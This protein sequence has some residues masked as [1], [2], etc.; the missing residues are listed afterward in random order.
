MPHVLQR[1]RDALSAPRQARIG[2]SVT[3][4]ADDDAARTLAMAFAASIACH[5]LL[6]ADW[7]SNPLPDALQ[8]SLFYGM[9]SAGA[10]QDASLRVE[11][12]SARG[13]DVTAEA[14]PPAAAPG[15]ANDIA[16]APAPIAPVRK[17]PAVPP[18]PPPPVDS[19]QGLVNVVEFDDIGAVDSTLAEAIGAEF[20]GTVDTRPQL[21]Q[22]LA[23]AYPEDALRAHRRMVVGV[24]VVV[25]EQGHVERTAKSFDDLVFAPAIDA[26]LQTAQFSPALRDGRAVRFWTVLVFDFTIQGPPIFP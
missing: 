2:A 18:P 25:D 24:L 3:T 22:E 26:A 21:Q 8:P 11:L 16:A 15:A 17:R 12:V 9:G 14:R 7:R 20:P 1:L 23:V 5:A 6:L 19:Q 13:T 4:V 10:R